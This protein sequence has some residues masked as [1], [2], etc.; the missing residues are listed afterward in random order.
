MIAVSGFCKALFQDLR[1]EHL[2]KGLRNLCASSY[3]VCSLVP[4]VRE[5]ILSELNGAREL[6]VVRR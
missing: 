4:K 2:S 5:P 6:R 3:M 1:A